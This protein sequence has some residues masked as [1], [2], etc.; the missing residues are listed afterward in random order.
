MIPR[1]ER[2]GRIRYTYDD[3]SFVY[4]AESN[5]LMQ[6]ILLI[7]HISCPLSSIIVIK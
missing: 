2:K 1:K 5:T 4:I 3:F 6:R 7:P